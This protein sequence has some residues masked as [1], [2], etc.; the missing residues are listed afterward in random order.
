VLEECIDIRFGAMF[1]L[2]I[3]HLACFSPFSNLDRTGSLSPC[4]AAAKL[5][6]HRKPPGEMDVPTCDLFGTSHSGCCAAM[7]TQALAEPLRQVV[8]VLR[9]WAYAATLEFNPYLGR[10]IVPM[11]L[12]ILDN[13][14]LGIAGLRFH[15]RIQ[16]LP[17]HGLSAT[18]RSGFRIQGPNAGGHHG[19]GHLTPRNAHPRNALARPLSKRRDG[20]H[21]KALLTTA[22]SAQ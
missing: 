7:C 22:Q 4:L 10:Q 3:R 11:A 15:H 12:K 19:H 1:A 8:K 14:V 5:E 9:L 16:E 18:S 17:P 21:K 13:F 20:H 2:F 6:Q